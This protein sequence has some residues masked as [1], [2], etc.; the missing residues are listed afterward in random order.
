[1]FYI[2]AYRIHPKYPK[3][4]CFHK[5]YQVDHDIAVLRTK[6]N[7]RSKDDIQ[8]IKFEFSSIQ[9]NLPAM[10]IGYT[11]TE[12][13]KYGHTGA[14][15]CGKGLICT[16]RDKIK[17]EFGDSGGPSVAFSGGLKECRRIGVLSGFGTW[18]D[19]CV[20]THTERNFIRSSMKNIGLVQ[21]GAVRESAMSKLLVMSSS[22]FHS[23][24]QGLFSFH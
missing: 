9:D 10:K 18:T 17:V 12:H 15:M 4:G 21:N 22:S 7:L 16:P 24:F 13:L 14:R 3:S 8:L 23:E 1:M 11:G 6:R 19:F 5:H 20:S 2:S